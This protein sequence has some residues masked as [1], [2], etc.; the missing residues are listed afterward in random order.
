MSALNLSTKKY[1]TKNLKC[2]KMVS[3]I[4]QLDNQWEQSTNLNYRH[5]G[6]AQKGAKTFVFEVTSRHNGRVIGYVRWYFAW[7]RYVLYPGDGT[8]FDAGCL[9]EIA[10]Y[11]EFKTKQHRELNP[12]VRKTWQ[13]KRRL[14]KLSGKLVI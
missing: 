8:L 4:E 12:V 1:L 9:H 7:R 14:D 13:E 10:E 6:R 3:M 11:C 2:E 5:R